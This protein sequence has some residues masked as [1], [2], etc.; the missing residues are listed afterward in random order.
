MIFYDDD[1]DSQF[2][3]VAYWKK[4]NYATTVFNVITLLYSVYTKI[5]WTMFISAHDLLYR[6]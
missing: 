6:V 4:G 3:F 2:F 5:C 1:D